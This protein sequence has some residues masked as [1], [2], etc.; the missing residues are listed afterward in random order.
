MII[1]L[2]GGDGTFLRTSGI[3]ENQDVPI[4][5]LNTDPTRSTGFLCNA[6]I[7]NDQKEKLIERIFD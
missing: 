6:K 7:Y 5:G 1:L 4:L 3:I 2:I